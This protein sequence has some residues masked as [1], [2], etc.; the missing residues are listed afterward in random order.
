MYQP[1]TCRIA[2]GSKCE[3][4]GMDLSGLHYGCSKVHIVDARMQNGSIKHEY[5]RSDRSYY[6]RVVS[7]DGT[8][9]DVYGPHESVTIC[10]QAG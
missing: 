10:A 9:S 7:A 6:T 3:K 2:M 4:C 1:I 8:M 5:D